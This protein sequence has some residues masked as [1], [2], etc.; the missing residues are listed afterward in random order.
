MIMLGIIYLPVEI[1]VAVF[2]VAGSW[3]KNFSEVTSLNHKAVN[4]MIRVR[5]IVSGS[6]LTSA[7]S[8]LILGGLSGVYHKD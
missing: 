8:S 7:E 1:K 5:A 2:L 3:K 6:S 4:N